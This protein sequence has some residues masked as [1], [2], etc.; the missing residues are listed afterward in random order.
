MEARSLFQ[1]ESWQRRLGAELWLQSMFVFL[2]GLFFNVC[3]TSGPSKMRRLGK[4]V[5]DKQENIAL[6][7]VHP[8]QP[9]TKKVILLRGTSLVVLIRTCSGWAL[10]AVCP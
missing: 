3:E 7:L 8:V 5:E 2:C 6:I 4:G 1:R 10:V 9:Q